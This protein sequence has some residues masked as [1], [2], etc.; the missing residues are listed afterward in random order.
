[1]W[2]FPLEQG[3]VQG[4]ATNRSSGKKEEI[5]VFCCQKLQ[6]RAP[7]CFMGV[8]LTEETSDCIVLRKEASADKC[9]IVSLTIHLLR[10]LI[11]SGS[12]L[13]KRG[14]PEDSDQTNRTSQKSRH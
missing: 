11:K 4:Q 3:L 9:F 10:W 1:M 8:W 13:N 12:G 7:C 5:T 6:P 2:G 14:S